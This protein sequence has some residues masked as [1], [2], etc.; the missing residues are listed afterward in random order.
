MSRTETKML[1][2]STTSTSTAVEDCT[3]KICNKGEQCENGTGAC[4]YVY[5]NPDHCGSIGKT[6][7]ATETCCFAEC[8]DL[9][10]SQR[11]CGTSYNDVGEDTCCDG[12]SVNTEES[13]DHCGSCSNQCDGGDQC[14]IGSCTDVNN[15]DSHCGGCGNDCFGGGETCCGGNCSN[16]SS[17]TSNCGGCDQSCADGED[18]AD[19]VCV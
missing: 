1:T 19:G 13:T 18:C 14:C 17:N 7:L 12:N 2:S 9:V 8:V 15:D 16:T 3:T 5:D 4:I 11:H 6:C 10:T